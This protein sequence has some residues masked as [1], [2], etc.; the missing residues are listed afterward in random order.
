MRIRYMR[1]Q[2]PDQLRT[3]L[4][5]SIRLNPYSG[6]DFSQFT[7]SLNGPRDPLLGHGSNQ[8]QFWNFYAALYDKYECTGSSITA[9]YFSTSATS[10]SICIVPVHEVADVSSE[11][12]WGM[13]ELKWVRYKQ[14]N[15]Y[16]QN[17]LKVRHYMSVKRMEGHNLNSINYASPV[18]SDPGLIKYW[19]MQIQTMEGDN[20]STTATL[21]LKM[22]YYVKFFRRNQVAVS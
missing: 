6:S 3:K 4:Q 22:T 5:M 20:I 14:S 9:Q 11:D 13:R 12:N 15:V 21:W 10:Y 7:L 16:N 1:M 19:F 8:P 18:A 2:F 17:S